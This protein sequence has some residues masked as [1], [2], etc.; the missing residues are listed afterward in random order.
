[1]KRRAVLAAGLLG[2]CSILPQRPYLE[3]RD[4]PLEASRG[5]KRPARPGA[6]VLLVRTLRAAPDL[7][8][9]GLRTLQPD[10]SLR[11]DP[12][13]EWSVT[14]PDAVE[15][16]LRRWLSD[17]GLFAAVL[18]PGSR[19]RPDLALEGELLALIA[20]PAHGI[21]RAA[22]SVVLIDL[23]HAQTRVRLQTEISGEAPLTQATG[24]GVAQS[25]CAALA[26]MLG[27]VEG[28]L[29]ALAYM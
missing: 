20:D 28:R 6:P 19:G 2:G 26:A 18:A 15:D 24:S 21:S 12:Y 29:A 14:P 27:N 23:R 3:K 25:G 13:E 5:S 22:M 4:W 8:A 10:G 1:M 11:V 17:S 16:Q 7:E 9:R